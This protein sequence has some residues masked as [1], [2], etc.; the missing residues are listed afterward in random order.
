MAPIIGECQ[1]AIFS[2]G[3][4]MT[5]GSNTFRSHIEETSLLALRFF[6]RSWRP[7]R[8]EAEAAAD[9]LDLVRKLRD[10]VVG[11]EDIAPEAKDYISPLAANIEATLTAHSIWGTVDL[12][13]QSMQL[14][15]AVQNFVMGA[16]GS[17]R[18]QKLRTDRSLYACRRG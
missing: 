15:A 2:T 7:V 9:V 18:R 4:D 6:A 17:G 3:H 16:E 14:A 8:L 10:V 13:D 1:S 5:S 11:S 12:Q